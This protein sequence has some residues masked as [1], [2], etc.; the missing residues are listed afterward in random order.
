M[1][2]GSWRLWLHFHL[3]SFAT[4]PTASVATEAR[5]PIHDV[6]DLAA[7]E[8][9][10]VEIDLDTWHPG[11]VRGMVLVDGRPHVG[12]V[13]LRV[14]RTLWQGNGIEVPG[15]GWLTTNTEGSF[16]A[17]LLPGQWTVQVELSGSFMPVEPAVR[18][19]PGKSSS[20]TVHVATATLELRLLT[21]S[22]EPVAHRDVQ[23]V[24][25]LWRVLRTT[26][27]AGRLEISS[28]TAGRYEVGTWKAP[29]AREADREAANRAG[30]WEAVRAAYIALGP[31]TLPAGQKRARVDVKLPTGE[32]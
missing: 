14:G 27:E 26:D 9:R 20:H 30:A 13:N 24:H 15:R 25:G 18:V 6:N 29:L 3:P 7:G 1:A 31:I 17:E 5:L 11:T 10:Q 23:L 21:S 8:T 2:E 16:E 32:R 19:E 12:R 28:M 4:T 22:G